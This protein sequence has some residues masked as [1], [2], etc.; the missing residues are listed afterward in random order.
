MINGAKLDKDHSSFTS[1]WEY[2][3]HK[4]REFSIHFSKNLSKTRAHLE[5]ELTRELNNLCNRSEMDNE[6][7]LKI[8]SLQSKIDN[9]YVT[10]HNKVH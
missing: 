10:L 3:K 6:T 9:L 8:L 2:L 4:I 7:K 1:K 5:E